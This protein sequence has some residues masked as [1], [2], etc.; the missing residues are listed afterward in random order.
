MGPI[1]M[2]ELVVIVI[3]LLLLTV[4]VVIVIA[5]AGFLS[6]R[7]KAP[8]PPQLPPQPKGIPERL[9]ELDDLR[10]RNLI[11]EAEYVDKRSRILRGI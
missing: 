10:S 11:T 6:S 9:A 4:P 1:G 5:L 3:V 7:R 8:Q 2:P